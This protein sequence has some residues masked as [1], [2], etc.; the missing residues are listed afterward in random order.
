MVPLRRDTHAILLQLLRK[1][2][3]QLGIKTTSRLSPPRC[4]N[5]VPVA[6]QPR[7]CVIGRAALPGSQPAP[8]GPAQVGAT[9]PG[10][11]PGAAASL[12]LPPPCSCQ[13]LLR[14]PR[15]RNCHCLWGFSFGRL[16]GPRT[17]SP[18]SAAACSR[19]WVT[20]FCIKSQESP[21]L[22]HIVP[23][24]PRILP[25][26]SLPGSPALLPP[27]LPH[28]RPRTRSGP[29]HAFQRNPVMGT[30]NTALSGIWA[31]R[32][33]IDTLPSIPRESAN[34]AEAFRG[35]LVDSL[36]SHHTTRSV[37]V[38]LQPASQHQQLGTVAKKADLKLGLHFGVQLGT[39]WLCN[40]KQVVSPLSLLTCE[41]RGKNRPTVLGCCAD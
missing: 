30:G 7:R 6:W 16:P 33:H 32:W 23:L 27:H 35:D 9:G 17:R 14:P 36:N 13:P 29:K 40:P 20:G 41:M 34:G 15:G 10:A 24:P 2:S 31:L 1:D 12:G 18:A 39:G 26:H 19:C 38:V 21:D 3:E 5:S 8:A 22:V 25:S 37:Q 28:S 11:G 4:Y